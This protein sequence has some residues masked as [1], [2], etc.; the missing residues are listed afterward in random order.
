MPTR[1]EEILA[2]L[3]QP[4]V[5]TEDLRRQLLELLIPS[6]EKPYIS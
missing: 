2:H 1:P 3:Q 4:G 6:P 5:L